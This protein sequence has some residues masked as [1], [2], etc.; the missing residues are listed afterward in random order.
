MKVK[1]NYSQI[2]LNPGLAYALLIFIFYFL[3]PWVKSGSVFLFRWDEA[4][5]IFIAQEILKTGFI[6][7]TLNYVGGFQN[8]IYPLL[9]LIITNFVVLTNTNILLISSIALQTTLFISLLIG[10][11][12]SK[13]IADLISPDRKLGLFT[14]IFYIALPVISSRL[15]YLHATFYANF[16]GISFMLMFIYYLLKY[17]KNKCVSSL[18]LSILFYSITL[19]THQL[20]FMMSTLFFTFFLIH[21][22]FKKRQLQRIF[23]EGIGFGLTALIL[24]I[25]YLVNVPLSKKVLSLLGLVQYEEFGQEVVR[26]ASADSLPILIPFIVLIICLLSSYVIITNSVYRKYRIFAFFFIFIVSSIELNK[27]GIHLPASFRY[28]SFYIIVTP[29]L[30]SVFV[31]FIVQFR[32]IKSMI[33]SFIVFGFVLNSAAIT[34]GFYKEELYSLQRGLLKLNCS[35]TVSY[36]R[37]APWIPTLSSSNI[38][39]AHVDI[40]NAHQDLMN[41]SILMFSTSTD[42]TTRLLLMKEKKVD[43]L[44]Y[45][46]NIL[47]Q[48]NIRVKGWEKWRYESL[49]PVSIEN[50]EDENLVIFKFRI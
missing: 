10:A 44:V 50:Y 12:I 8:Y 23:L 34:N 33:I 46:K 40:Y 39:Y 49:Y 16:V 27:L 20:V 43:C 38:Y 4:V 47:I 31:N 14:G 42:L 15:F 5:Y 3:I 18:I 9:Y 35:N 41:E 36:F 11:T 2:F 6:P 13:K 37:I 32:S 25:G 28:D 22:L 1:H 26:K 29:L 48:D 19:F 24:N 7:S 17:K 45:E 21:E 30:L